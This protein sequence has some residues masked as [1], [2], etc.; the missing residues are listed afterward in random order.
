MSS[1]ITR[2]LVATLA[3]SSLC[4]SPAM[5]PSA[6]AAP[7]TIVAT[8]GQR[9]ATVTTLQANLVKLGFLKVSPTGYYGAQTTAAV[10]AFQKW[11]GN[12]QT[13]VVTDYTFKT[14]ATLAAQR[15]SVAPAPAKA[16]PS[17]GST[18]T[19]VARPGQRGATVTTLQANLQ[20]M[21]F[22]KVAPTGYYGAQTTAAVK[23]FQKW[24]GNAQ[25]GVVTDRTFKVIASIAATRTAV[26]PVK[27]AAKLDP[28]CYTGRTVCVDKTKL[29][30]YW[31]VNGKIQDDWSVR[32]GRPS[33]PTR[34]GTFRI[35]SKHTN[36][37]STLYDVDMPYTQFFSGGEAIH[38]SVDFAINGYYGG[39]SHGCVNMRDKA[40]AK[41]LFSQTRVGDRVVVYRS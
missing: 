25:T 10:K 33:L 35:N 36:W 37:H 12:A 27:P 13:G 1:K 5:A 38:Y 20:R 31:V 41:W 22:L 7:T 16:A 3:A 39:G 34:E 30:M 26:A 18:A 23:A 9:G 11:N 40:G 2:A 24:N 4:L 32:V 19:V 29:R 17:T 28:R 15:K 8:S 6:Q 14:I 21:G